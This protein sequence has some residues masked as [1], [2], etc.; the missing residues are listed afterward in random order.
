MDFILRLFTQIPRRIRNTQSELW[1]A[2]LPTLLWVHRDGKQLYSGR[3]DSSAHSQDNVEIES[4][5]AMVFKS[6]L[7]D[8]N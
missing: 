1:D 7:L 3:V 6:N 4:R 2:E 5:S 8:S